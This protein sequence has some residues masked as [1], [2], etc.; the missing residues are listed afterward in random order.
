MKMV[1]LDSQLKK[2]YDHSQTHLDENNRVE[3]IFNICYNWEAKQI[4]DDNTKLA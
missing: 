4:I 2:I 1:S 3:Q